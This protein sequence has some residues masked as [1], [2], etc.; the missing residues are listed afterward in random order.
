MN[1]EYIS[2]EAA[3]NILK[4]SKS[5]IYR[6]A[7]AGVYP[8]ATV[9]GTMVFPRE[10]IETLAEVTGIAAREEHWTFTKST[11]ADI[12]ERCQNSRRIYGEDDYVTYKRALEWL[13]ISP[14][15][16]MS[17]KDGKTLF[18]GTTI[19]PV[20]EDVIWSV[21]RDEIREDHIPNSAIK[22]WTDPGLSVYILTIATIKSGNAV[23]D[24]E[25]GMFLIKNTIRWAISL[26]MQHDIKN[27]YGMGVTPKGQALLEALGFKLVLSVQDGARKTYRLDN[28]MQGSHMLKTFLGKVDKRE[29][30][31]DEEK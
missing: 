2:V 27:W 1:D 20:D 9:N 12:W 25:R 13:K 21:S 6:N 31:L 3:M 7:K 15:T 19:L 28:L 23:L 14:D 4:K 26:Q 8:Y 16:M 22:K 30:H 5:T 10:A 17:T 18:G 29:V 11:N 24:A